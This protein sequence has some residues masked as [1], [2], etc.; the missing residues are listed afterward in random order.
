MKQ[1]CTL[2]AISFAFVLN[3]KVYSQNVAQNF[4]SQ[5]E[6]NSLISHCWTFN[7]VS[8][9][10]TSQIAG[11]G[12]VVTQL[13]TTSEIMT[14]ELQ[15]PTTLN[16]S[17]S[18][19]TIADIN[20]SKTLK[21]FLLLNGAETILETINLQ[22]D[23]SGSFSGTFTSANTPGQNINGSRK[24][25]FRVNNNAS[26]VIDNLTVNAPYTYPGGCPM[27]NSPLPVTFAGF[28]AKTLSGGISLTWEVGTEENVSGYEVQKSV[29]GSNFSK[30]GFVAANNKSSYGFID[31]KHTGPGYYRIKSVDIDGKYAYSTVVRINGEQSSTLLKAFPMPVENQLTIQHGSA[32]KASRIEIISVDGRTVQC[33]PIASGAQQTI[34]DFSSIKPGTYIARVVNSNSTETLKIIKQ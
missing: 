14:P 5:A 22:S 32:N 10:G 1:I 27:A 33:T 9:T 2:I 25:I 15:I 31:S 18:Y 21:V 8:F 11:T 17:F 13:G 19:N 26:V 3:T 24:I 29:N 12:S 30:I 23:P 7:N 20:G 16:I 6:V 34:I 28:N 4:E